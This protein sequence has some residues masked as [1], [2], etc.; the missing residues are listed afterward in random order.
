MSK[1]AVIIST[2]FDLTESQNFLRYSKTQNRLLSIAFL[3]HT[4]TVGLCLG[5]LG[6]GHLVPDVSEFIGDCPMVALLVATVM[7]I[8]GY[9][10]G[11]SKICA[12]KVPVNYIC[13]LIFIFTLVYSV[14]AADATFVKG[15][16]HIFVSMILGTAIANFLYVTSIRDYYSGITGFLISFGIILLVFIGYGF[17]LQRD[18]LLLVTYLVFAVL[19]SFLVCTGVERLMKN[20][21]YYL[22]KDD[23]VLVALKVITV[24]PLV[25]HLIDEDRT[26]EDD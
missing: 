21:D 2:N 12:R 18:F 19:L 10:L 22:L 25:P 9:T 5:I 1:P 15:T 20:R 16:L 7:L 4:F 3:F 14:A 6:L 13:L 11:Y 8:V 23:Y 17:S 24:F 26:G